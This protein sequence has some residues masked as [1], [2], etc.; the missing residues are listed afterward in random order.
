MYKEWILCPYPNLS[1]HPNRPRI[2]EA[3]R[4]QKTEVY[5]SKLF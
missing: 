4:H 1:L 5:N 3:K 2:C